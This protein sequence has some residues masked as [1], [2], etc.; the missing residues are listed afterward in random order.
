LDGAS[1]CGNDSIFRREE[2]TAVVNKAVL[3]VMTMAAARRTVQP[4]VMLHGRTR[5]KKR[6]RRRRREGLSGP[7]G[8]WPKDPRTDTRKE[9][10]AVAART[11]VRPQA[12][13]PKDAR[14]DTRKEAATAAARRAVRPRASWPKDPRTERQRQRR[15]ELS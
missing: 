15:E 1:G 3:M 9:A 14:T 8:S 13:W 2:F 12:S 11:A 5:G 4:R 7:R 6:R 10:V